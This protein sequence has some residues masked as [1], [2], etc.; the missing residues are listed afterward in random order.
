MVPQARP[1]PHDAIRKYMHDTR[2]WFGAG[3]GDFEATP[4]QGCGFAGAAMDD[5]D[6]ALGAII[7]E[8]LLPLAWGKR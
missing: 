8:R 4:E 6:D 2:E 1:R 3:D 5:G 7:D